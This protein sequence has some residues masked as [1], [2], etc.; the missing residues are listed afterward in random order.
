[1]WEKRKKGFKIESSDD[2]NRFE[3]SW[4]GFQPITDSPRLGYLVGR[5]KIAENEYARC[6]CGSTSI[7][8]GQIVKTI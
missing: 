8:I 6:E 5:E 3:T 7:E 2:W 4:E 1:L